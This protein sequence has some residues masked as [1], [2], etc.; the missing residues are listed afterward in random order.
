MRILIVDD[1]TGII[2]MLLA[3]LKTLPGH[4]VRVATSGDKAIEHAAG[5][6]G[7]DL[8][9]TDVVMEPMDGFTLRD[10]IHSR[11]PNAR[12]ILLSGYD[13][14]DYPEQTAYHQLLQKPVDTST[15][16]A[17]VQRELAAVVPAAPVAV[18]ATGVP[19]ARAAVPTGAPSVAS[20]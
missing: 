17:A 6:G 2:Q 12:T 16:I 10:Q 4:D 3:T 19:Q 11:Y 1:D 8:L 9:I 18:R 7:V 13:L 20:A 15:L 14:S 5:M